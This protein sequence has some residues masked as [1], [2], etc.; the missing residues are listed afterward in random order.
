MVS[1]VYTSSFKV[2]V[3]ID[4]N[5]Y[6]SSAEV[7]ITMQFQLSQKAAEWRNVGR[8]RI[9]VRPEAAEWRNVSNNNVRFLEK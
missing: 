4:G 3:N 9:Q 5:K 7:F 6:I 1:L 8:K 2:A